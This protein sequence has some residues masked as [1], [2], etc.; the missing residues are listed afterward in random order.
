M[1]FFLDDFRD[2]RARSRSCK[3]SWVDVSFIGVPAL[4]A[5]VLPAIEQFTSWLGFL[6]GGALVFQ[7]AV[8]LLAVIATAYVIGSTTLLREP[9]DGLIV[10]DAADQGGHEIA[11]YRFCS[12]VRQTAKFA[13]A[14]LVV[15]AVAS[16]WAVAP[17]SFR[18]ST[19]LAGYVCTANGFGLNGAFVQ[20]MDKSGAPVSAATAADDR[21]FFFARLEKW[22]MHPALVRLTAECKER[23]YSLDAAGR[24][25]S[26][27]SDTVENEGAPEVPVWITDCH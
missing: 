14:P 3:N 6:P 2:R 23:S 8:P 25:K 13:L 15:I 5:A 12:A 26:C 20:A 22:K 18:R 19:V 27:P 16:L 11:E 24:G 1:I 17:N 21:G 9:S 7:G 4:I 10:I